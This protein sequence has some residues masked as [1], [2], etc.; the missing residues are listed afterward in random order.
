MNPVQGKYR[1]KKEYAL[2]Y[3]ELIT[4]AKYRGTVTY[5]EIAQIMGLPLSGNHMS[6]EVGWILG[7]ISADELANGRPMLSAIAI[8]VNGKP[9]AGFYDWARK[10]GRLSAENDLSFWESECRSVYDTWKVKLL[11]GQPHG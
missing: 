3:T 5:Q 6:R 2:I 9:G 1:S 8:G 11:K 7:E 4:A 10:L